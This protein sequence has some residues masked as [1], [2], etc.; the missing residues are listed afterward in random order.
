MKLKEPVKVIESDL[1]SVVLEDAEGVN[2]FWNLKGE[3]DGYCMPGDLCKP[4]TQ[5]DNNNE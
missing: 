2:Y 5:G 1:Y 3:Y 4:P